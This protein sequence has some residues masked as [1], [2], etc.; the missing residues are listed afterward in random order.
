MGSGMKRLAMKLRFSGWFIRRYEVWTTR[1]T[2]SGTF[3]MDSYFPHRGKKFTKRGA[4]RFGDRLK[5]RAKGCR[6]ERVDLG[7]GKHE[8]LRT[9]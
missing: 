5:L 1:P 7:T 8:V 9:F 3:S 4:R 6:V 2:K